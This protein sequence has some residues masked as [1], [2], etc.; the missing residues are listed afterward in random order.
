MA[1]TGRQKTREKTL[2][3]RGSRHAGK[4]AEAANPRPGMPKMPDW[5]DELGQQE[6]RRIVPPL[7]K[8]R[9]LTAGDASGLAMI[10]QAHSVFVTQSKRLQV[11]Q[12]DNSTPMDLRRVASIASDAHKSYLRGLEAFGCTPATRNRV[13]PLDD[14]KPSTDPFAAYLNGKAS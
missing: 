8:R 5:L 7:A 6:W 10:C 1:K 14:S 3:L 12:T 13:V 2:Q 11:M 4:R 9:I